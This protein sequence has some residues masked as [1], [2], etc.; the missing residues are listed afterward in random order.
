M[1]KE[2]P[3]C[4]LFLEF[5]LFP[6]TTSQERDTVNSVHCHCFYPSSPLFWRKE[7][8]LLYPTIVQKLTNLILFKTN[9]KEWPAFYICLLHEPITVQSRQGMEEV[10]FKEKTIAA[11]ALWP[12]TWIIYDRYFSQEH[13]I[14][15]TKILLFLTLKLA[16]I[17]RRLGRLS[18]FSRIF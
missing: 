9:F 2:S 10:I 8:N 14:S 15:V 16:V 11:T 4:R 17:L 6:H 12:S 5:D 7:N 13:G 3:S 18:T 1:A